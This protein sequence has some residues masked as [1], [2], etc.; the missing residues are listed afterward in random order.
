MVTIFLP[1]YIL[2]NHP[3]QIKQWNGMKQHQHPVGTHCGMYRKEKEKS[4]DHT[5][6]SL[7]PEQEEVPNPPPTFT[8]NAPSDNH[9][10]N[11]QQQQAAYPR[12]EQRLFLL[13][14]IHIHHLKFFQ[15]QWDKRIPSLNH[16][17][18][19][20]LLGVERCK[21][22]LP[23]ADGCICLCSQAKV[24]PQFTPIVS[25]CIFMNNLTE[26]GRTETKKPKPRAQGRTGSLGEAWRENTA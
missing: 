24:Y 4:D 17:R 7:K 21:H 23:K 20:S 12:R 16:G 1:F 25:G 10:G 9:T 13:V 3:R 5:P 15:D 26:R 18:T 19:E 11:Q 14:P 22:L 2:I 8:V 6:Y